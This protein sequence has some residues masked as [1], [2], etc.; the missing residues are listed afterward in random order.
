MLT[1]PPP[2]PN[3]AAPNYQQTQLLASPNARSIENLQS[4]ARM[5]MKT[6]GGLANPG[7]AASY[8][9]AGTAMGMPALSANPL[10]HQNLGAIIAALQGTTP[11]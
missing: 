11:R 4:Y 2:S 10:Q 7:N 3:V 1:V 9:V 5:G 8:P 6:P